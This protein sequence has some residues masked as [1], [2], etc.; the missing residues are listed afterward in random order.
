MEPLEHVKVIPLGGGVVEVRMDR[1][2][3]RNA[4][5]K[6]LW[7]ELGTVFSSVIPQDPTARCVILTGSGK[8]FSSGIDV[9]AMG[10]GAI[11][12]ESGGKDPALR[13]MRVLQEGA[14]WQAAWKAV[15]NCRVPVIAAVHT[16][17]YGA[18]L[19]LI[20]WA[21]VRMCTADTV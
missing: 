2:E 4:M 6:R 1:P 15:N 5:N 7:S 19:E 16:G 3:K 21:D 10:F 12:D 11:G 17:C 18:A 20:A 8:L 9:S 13:G 14:E